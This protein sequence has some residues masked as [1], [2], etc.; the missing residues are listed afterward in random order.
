MGMGEM[1]SNGQNKAREFYHS[2]HNQIMELIEYIKKH[3]PKP[4]KA[5]P[6]YSPEGDSLTFI[7]E[8]AM[9][10]RERVDDFLT[11]YRA[12]DAKTRH[13]AKDR[14]VGC[15]LKGLPEV[16]DLLGA[17]DLTINNS[18]IRL[19]MIFLGCMTRAEKDVQHFY[20]DIAER[21]EARKAEISIASLRRMPKAVA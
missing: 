10:Y 1:R 20:I 3:R 14:L 7:F 17:F 15:Q 6:V 11:V 19:T 21:D 4:F 2:I 13:R 5:T 9:Y 8:D 12:I 18:P 16:L